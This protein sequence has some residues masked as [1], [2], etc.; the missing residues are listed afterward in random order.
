M[1]RI[2]KVI[3]MKKALSFFLSIVIMFSFIA[4]LDFSAL[5]DEIISGSCGDGTTF[6]LDSSGTLTVSGSGYRMN[7]YYDADDTRAPWYA[8]KEQ[9]KKVVIEDGVINIGARA[10]KDCENLAEISFGTIDTIGDHAFQNCSSLKTALLPSTCSWIWGYAFENCTS[11]QRAYVNY[12]SSTEAMLPEGMFKGCTSLAVLGLGTGIH[13]LGTDS[14]AGCDNFKTIISDNGNIRALQ[15]YNTLGWSERSGECSDNTY[16]SQKLTWNYDLDSGTLWFT[17][18][19]DMKYYDEGSRP[20]DQFY[21]AINKI[22]FSNTNGLCS[23]TSDSFHALTSLEYVDFKN[24]REIGWR[25]FGDCSN[26]KYIDFDSTLTSIWDWAFERNYSLDHITF[27]DGSE[28]LRIRK[29]AFSNCNKTTYWLNFPSNLRYVEDWAFLGTKFN[30]ITFSSTENIEIGENAFGTKDRDFYIRFFGPAGVNNGV[31][32]WVQKNKDEYR[33]NWFYYCSGEHIYEQST[34]APTCTKDGYNRYGCKYCMADE[35]KSDYVAKTGH[36]YIC[37]GTDEANVL[38][39][40][41]KC[42]DE[43]LELSSVE[44]D[45]IFL[46]AISKTAG[47]SKYRQL[48]YN[49][50]VDINADGVVNAK[51]F[52]QIQ[53]AFSSA[54]TDNKETTV[55]PSETY[56]QIEGFGASAAWW[57]QE[58]GSWENADKI[59]KMLYS[60]ENGIGLDI[61]RYNLGAGSEDQKDY[62]LYVSGARTHCFMQEDG[63]Y[64]WN[65]DPYAIHCLDLAQQFNPDLKV[66]LFAN[67]P[68][69]FMT[70]SGKTYGPLDTESRSNLA[71]ENYQAFADYIATCAE[72]FI[73]SGYNVTEV[74]P[75]NEP[76]WD[77]AGWYNGDGS[78]SSNQEGC[79]YHWWEAR[80]FY[81]YNMIPTLKNNSKLNGKVELAVWECAQ[82]NHQWLW[83]GFF[84]NLFS[85]R[86]YDYLDSRNRKQGKGPADTNG[87]IRSYVPYLDTH[88]YWA[89]E[90]DRRAV[91]NQLAGEFYGQK[92]KCSEY[93]QMTNDA[94]SGV[95]G[96]IQNEGNTNGMTIDYGL[97]MADIIYQDFTILNACEW[98]WWT[99]CGKG[100]Y[101]DSLLYISDKNHDDIQPSKRF[102]C[103]GNFSKFIDV[104]ARRI[105]IE[106]GS[107]FASNLKTKRTYHWT[108]HDDDNNITNEG[109][110]KNNYIE[111]LA[112][113]NPDGTV[114]VIYINNSDT[115]EYT[116]IQG[117]DK[118]KFNS[119]VT[120]DT[121]D[122][123]HFQSGSSSEAVCIPARSLTTVVLS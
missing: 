90:D 14:L 122:L 6:V 24:I 102:W 98:D 27:K 55:T 19:G 10:F 94:N 112:F 62:A 3:R 106:T 83:N 77:W 63:T 18:S 82:L 40:C 44:I 118:T 53:K 79:H 48:N 113:L 120:S 75:I 96:H 21:G 109:V 31:F 2:N 93:C 80:N 71:E 42:D 47:S 25:S 4:A 101:P 17:G 22:D 60:E 20:W 103:M 105:K 7:D 123:K 8:N 91:A 49:S 50:K 64:N 73:D 78:Q 114:V 66:T 52:A 69:Y 92:V 57:A 100:V 89:S 46:P 119:F 76:E 87:N 32:D 58:V 59:L 84:E 43:S 9:I 97:A 39:R 81:N 16:S 72:H 36:S 5:A 99:A 35:L 86:D 13:W 41:S 34:V 29:G 28:P 70:I 56:Q 108:F 37:T 26:L 74:S 45:G 11:L 88:S 15:E 85:S 67:S 110:D 116:K 54:V 107:D 104:G 61:F 1:I 121:M 51:D 117:T 115:I 111:Q 68:P 12:V 33:Y 23:T 95:L 38:Y 30:Y 65:N